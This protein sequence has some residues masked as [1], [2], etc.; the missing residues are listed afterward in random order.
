MGLSHNI[1]IDTSESRKHITSDHGPVITKYNLGFTK[2]K[3]HNSTKISYIYK[4]IE[5]IKYNSL[6]T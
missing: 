1:T 5:N 4:R 6:P 3:K 2:D